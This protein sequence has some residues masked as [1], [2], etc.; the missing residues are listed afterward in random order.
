MMQDLSADFKVIVDHALTQ[1]TPLA[2][3]GGRS[4]SFYGRESN[5]QPLDLR[6]HNGIVDYEPTELVLTARCGTPLSTI[7][8][9]L[10]EQQ[11]MLAFEP[12]YFDSNATLGG[13][14]A[15]GLSGPRRPFGGAVRD[16]VLGIRI[17]NG[18]SEMVSFGGKV[19]K[20]VAGYDLS[21]LMA[22]SLGT[23]AIL[24]QVSLKV[25]PRPAVE[26]TLVHEVDAAQALA[27][28]NRWG[29][30][31]LPLSGLFWDNGFLYA[32]LS[33]TTATIDTAAAKLGGDYLPD[34]ARLW[35]D[36]RD[37][38]LKFFGTQ[39]TLWRLSV[40]PATP[41]LELS[42]QWL[43][44]WGAAQR[45]LVSDEAPERIFHVAAECGGHACRFRSDDRLAQIF[46][47]LPAPL[48]RLHKQLKQAFDPHHIFNPQRM[49]PE[50]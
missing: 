27:L 24:L 47:P 35:C 6:G 21:R 48:Y 22:G 37:H 19:M 39:P 40:A 26:R 45:W 1:K 14:V 18:R 42:G 15:S 9:I 11:Q 10:Q 30:E 41:M 33:G 5:G 29:R 50:L 38:R 23:L 12:P 20:N 43:L 49:Y 46:Q 7:E 28:M 34:D 32:R 13:A 17:L 4:K 31:S 16:A 25:V 44:D 3:H 2:L 36:L 8:A